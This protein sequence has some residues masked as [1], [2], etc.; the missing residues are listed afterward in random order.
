MATII[1]AHDISGV[2]RCSLATALGVLPA[3]GHNCYPLPTA[4]LSQ[5][6]GFKGYVYRDM[7]ESL[8][9][10]IE[11][12]DSLDL[13]PDMIYT[14]FLGNG[15]QAKM[16]VELTRRYSGA[17]VVVDPVMGDNGRIYSCYDDKF[18][19]DMRELANHADILLPNTTE[20]NLLCG[21]SPAHSFPESDSGL[22][23]LSLQLAR[24]SPKLKYI[25]ITGV[26]SPDGMCNVLLDVE[27][28]GILRIP[29]RHSG[30]S[31][32]GSGDL[33]ASILC[34]LIQN[35]RDIAD[36]IKISADFVSSA[37]DTMPKD[38][39]TRYGICYEPLL[40]NFA[41]AVAA[42]NRRT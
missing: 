22:L 35:G 2:G 30:A 9:A 1:A 21:R 42:A 37:V 33:F 16:L 15:R 11:A 7:T 24:G 27:K 10:F 36:A 26:N 4:V 41:A 28:S 40:A 5:Q 39:D 8:P 29:C 6:T 32:S 3:F 18:A 34:S 13:K 20:F 38:A 17:L 14:G 12:W 19:E 25:V 23:S 31:Y